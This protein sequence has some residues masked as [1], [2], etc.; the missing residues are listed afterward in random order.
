VLI[1]DLWGWALLLGFLLHC[2]AFVGG[3]SVLCLFWRVESLAVA[4]DEL[5]CSSQRTSLMLHACVCGALLPCERGSPV[6]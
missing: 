6:Q 1:F 5:K 4:K 2:I 3:L